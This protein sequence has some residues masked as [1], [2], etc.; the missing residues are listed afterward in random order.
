MKSDLI[1]IWSVEEACRYV[2]LLKALK[3]EIKV[4]FEFVE[5]IFGN[6]NTRVFDIND[7]PI[8]KFKKHPFIS[9]LD[10][11]IGAFLQVP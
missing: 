4:F 10:D 8:Y 11:P 7:R 6:G 5:H 9:L 3:Y 2:W 1:A